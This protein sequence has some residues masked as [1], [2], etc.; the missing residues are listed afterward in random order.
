MFANYRPILL[1]RCWRALENSRSLCH[2]AFDSILNPYYNLIIKKISLIL[3]D[4][5]LHLILFKKS[6][7]E[8]FAILGFP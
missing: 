4:T 1:S 6:V 2:T 7:T 8:I 5:K 3:K